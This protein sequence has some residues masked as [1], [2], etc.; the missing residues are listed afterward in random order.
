MQRFARKP[1]KYKIE[2]TKTE[3]QPPLL[4]NPLFLLTSGYTFGLPFGTFLLG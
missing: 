4:I 2:S 1:E 3:T